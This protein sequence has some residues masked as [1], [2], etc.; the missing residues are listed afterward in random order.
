MGRVIAVA[1][2]KGGVGK[3]TTAINLAAS[4]AANEFR[5]LLIDM[6]PQGNCTTGMGIDKQPGMPTTYDAVMGRLPLSEAAGPHGIRRTTALTRRQEPRRRQSRTGRPGRTR[7]TTPTRPCNP[8]ATP[9]TT[10]SLIAPPPS[11]SSLSTALSPP[12]PSLSPSSASSSLSKAYPNSSI[13]STGSA[14][15][16]S[17]PSR[18]KA[19]CSRCT[20]TARISPAKSPVRPEGILPKPGLRDRHPSQH[21]ARGS[22][23]LRKTHHQLRPALTRRRKLHQTRQGDCPE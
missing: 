19:F 1:N 12:T 8:S 4:L 22:A 13:R 7:T 5:I 9:I 14:T 6:D 23:Q 15:A 17:P 11:T 3:T 18:S 21:P 16:S 2:Q 10:Q 20:T